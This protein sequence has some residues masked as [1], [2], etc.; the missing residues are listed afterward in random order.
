MKSGDLVR[1]RGNKHES[2]VYAS[3][4][5]HPGYTPSGELRDRW[6]FIPRGE[7]VLCIE[8]DFHPPV[9]LVKPATFLF[10]GKLVSTYQEHFEAIDETG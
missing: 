4:F 2:G 5:V 7:V 9:G 3:L 6:C 1:C 10:R 8:P